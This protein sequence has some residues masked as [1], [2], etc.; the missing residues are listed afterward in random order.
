[1]LRKPWTSNTPAS[2][3]GTVTLTSKRVPRGAVVCGTTAYR[4]RSLL[5]KGTFKTRAGRTFAARPRS[6]C[7]NSP[8]LAVGIGS[9]GF[10]V[11]LE[12]AV[13]GDDQISFVERAVD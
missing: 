10:V 6:T 1:M 2:S 12:G 7:H 9:L 8:R 13:G 4:A 11:L 3:P 5:R